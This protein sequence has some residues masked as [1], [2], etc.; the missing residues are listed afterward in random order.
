[1]MLEVHVVAG[2]AQD[3]LYNYDKLAAILKEA[4]SLPLAT[5]EEL[6]AVTDTVYELERETWA[7]RVDQKRYPSA[8]SI[9]ASRSLSKAE[10][11]E[12]PPLERVPIDQVSL[13]AETR[14][15]DERRD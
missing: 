4:P 12:Q 15:P 9:R 5:Y 7:D 2:E 6:V 10:E 14:I 8:V 11:A 13:D 1:L 3:F